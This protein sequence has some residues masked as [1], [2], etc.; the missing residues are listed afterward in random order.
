ML[1]AKDIIGW[2]KQPKEND[3]WM[4][5]NYKKHNKYEMY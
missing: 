5:K 1:D 3:H 2:A 4:S